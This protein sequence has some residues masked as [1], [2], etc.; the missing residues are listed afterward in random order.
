MTTIT[1]LT[2]AFRSPRALPALR[3]RVRAGQIVSLLLAAVSGSGVKAGE[4][5]AFAKVGGWPGAT[6]NFGTYTKAA[7]GTV[8]RSAAGSGWKSFSTSSFHALAAGGSASTPGNGGFSTGYVGGSAYWF[9]QITISSPS[10]APGTQGRVFFTLY[11]DGHVSAGPTVPGQNRMYRASIGYRWAGIT[12]GA[13]NVADPD[14]GESY[15][16]EIDVWS[17]YTETLGGNFRNQPRQHSMLFRFGQPIDFTVAIHCSGETP[18]DFASKARC[19]LRCTGWNGFFGIERPF[20]VHAAGGIPVADATIASQ[21]GTNYAQASVSSY[22][23][24]SNLYQLAE[25]SMLDDSNGDGLS[26]LVEYALGRNPVEPASTAAFTPGTAV[27][28]GSSYPSFTFRRPRLGGRPGDLSYTPK[29]STSLGTWVPDGIVTTVA[30][31]APDSDTET[32]TVRSTQPTSGAVREFLSLE[33]T[34][35]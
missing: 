35:P 13:D 17:A 5:A 9:D 8:T 32:V 26:N 28:G 30:P 14:V 27:V 4:V 31:T 10:V 1:P 24:W 6:N 25:T 20:D 2:V 16:E 34:K 22:Q 11:F 15:G 29:R 23:Q 7:G 3:R 18:R 33:V 21:T 19:E 12:D